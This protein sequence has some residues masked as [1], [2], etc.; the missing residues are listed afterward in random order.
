MAEAVSH[1]YNKKLG[2]VT[3]YNMKLADGTILEGIAAEDIDVTNASLAEGHGHAMKRDDDEELDEAD[4]PDFLD[5]DKDGDKEESMKD[6]AANKK[7][8]D[9]K[10]AIAGILRKHKKNKDI[11]EAIAGILRNRLKG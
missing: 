6:A 8:K 2:K 5:I 10:E 9:L 11:K 4:K 1:N 7:D 3:H